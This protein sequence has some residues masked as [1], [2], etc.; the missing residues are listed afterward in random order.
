MRLAVEK[1]LSPVSIIEDAFG[2]ERGTYGPM[3]SVKL[4][5]GS[6]TI[7]IQL[8][9]SRSAERV[10]AETAPLLAVLKERCPAPIKT[11]RK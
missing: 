6:E 4:P 7:L 5:D 9:K 3:A 1:D 11:A 8:V 2:K 10:Q